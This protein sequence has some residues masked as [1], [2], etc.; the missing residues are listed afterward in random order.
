MKIIATLLTF[1]LMLCG[2]PYKYG[3]MG[4]K[5]FDCSGYV[6]YCY[7]TGCG[8]DLHGRTA[9]E[10]GYNQEFVLIQTV[11]QLLPGDIMCFDTLA[12]GDLSDHLGI[13]LGNRLFVHCSSGKGKVII[14][15]IQDNY[16]SRTFSW[17]RRVIEGD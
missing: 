13:Y 4:P 15:P 16:Y 5:T 6:I 11:D 12:D 17:G 8:I 9:K 2:S 3:T 14:S 10:I 1:A 7:Q